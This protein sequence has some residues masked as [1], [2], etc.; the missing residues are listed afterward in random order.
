MIIIIFIIII[1]SIK[2]AMMEIMQVMKVKSFTLIINLIIMI[3]INVINITANLTD[4]SIIFIIDF[5]H[6]SNITLSIFFNYYFLSNL[7][8]I[9]FNIL[10]FYFVLIY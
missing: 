8:I 3:I 7:Y 10:L 6:N 1:L 2:I 5:S 4:Y 9:P